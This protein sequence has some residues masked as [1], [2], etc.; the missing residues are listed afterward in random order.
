MRQ[1]IDALNETALPEAAGDTFNYDLKAKYAEF[2]DKYFGG[3]LPEC[4]LRFGILKGAG[5]HC[6]C[7]MKLPPPEKRLSPRALKMRG[8]HRT[9]GATLVPGSISITLST[10]YQREPAGLDAILLHE[11]IHAWF[12]HTEQFHV[13][14]GLEFL[15]MR[16][17][18]SQ[19]SG[20][21]VPLRD[22]TSDLSVSSEVGNRP[23][24]VLIYRK[25]GEINYAIVNAN[26]M[27]NV[28][29]RALEKV[30]WI[31]YTRRSKNL[32][33]TMKIVSG[34]WWTRKS[35]TLPVQRYSAK[36]IYRMKP[37]DVAEAMAEFETGEEIF[38]YYGDDAAAA[39]AKADPRNA[40]NYD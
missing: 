10:V 29:H 18:I 26:A 39:A 28:K 31:D 17:K 11:M 1:Y 38:D 9:H 24:A 13:D 14:H 15:E 27:R 20:I 2:N 8:L 32:H 22:S 40:G 30:K 12:F 3:E 35:L 16:K 36:S 5:G 4:K 21:D 25:N 23:V 7:K 34:P 6:T 19:M 37:A 33:V